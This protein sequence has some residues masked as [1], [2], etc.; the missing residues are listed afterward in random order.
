MVAYN[1]QA[2]F[3]EPI[4][5][6]VKRNTIRRNGK[7]RRNGKSRHASPGD[8]VQLYT[9]QRTKRCQKIIPDQVCNLRAP[10]EIQVGSASIKWIEIGGEPIKSL[11]E[12]ESFARADGFFSLAHMSQFWF[13]FHGLG[14]FKDASVIGWEFQ[15]GTS[16]D[17]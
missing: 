10:I 14:L 1:F 7:P 2:H 16:D 11:E 6:G 9:G 8:M 13:K 15:L 12:L 17:C 4:R 3:A 5:A